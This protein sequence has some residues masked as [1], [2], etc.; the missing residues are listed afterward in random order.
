[1]V[2]ATS[3][4]AIIKAMTGNKAFKIVCWVAVGII[5]AFVAL[6]FLL[7]NDW[8]IKKAIGWALLPVAH[9]CNRQPSGGFGNSHRKDK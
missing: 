9:L 7:A 8:H 3:R 1:M 2:A 4:K 6:T 5:V